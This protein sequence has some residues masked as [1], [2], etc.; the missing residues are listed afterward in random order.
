MSS[1][2]G[3]RGRPRYPDVLTPT[4]WQIAD[5]VRHGLSNREIA[6][7]RGISPDAVKFHVTNAIGKLGLTGRPQLRGWTGIPATSALAAHAPAANAPAG[8]APAMPAAAPTGGAMTQLGPI[9]QISRTV[10]DIE[11]AVDWY[12]RVLG[13]PHLYTFGTLAFF[14]CAGTRLFLSLPEPG[15]AAPGTSSVLYFTVA[16]IHRGYD[17]LR[18]RGVEFV[19]APHLIHRH[20]SG[21]EE[22][23]AFFTDPDGGTLALISQVTP[24]S[25]VTPTVAGPAPAGP[26]GR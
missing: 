16:D 7:L 4:E 19:G 6:R 5:A 23:M 13:L 11:R 26:A 17:D 14:D 12:G 20:A 9:G 21:V 22:W 24:P 18:S 10:S 15:A 2:P 8:S 1:S 25:Q 3:R